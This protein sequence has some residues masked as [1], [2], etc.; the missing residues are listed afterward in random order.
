MNKKAQGAI[1]Y[2]LIIG[3]AII[4]I[5]IVVIALTGILDSGDK[6]TISTLNDYDDAQKTLRYPALGYAIKA[7]AGEIT[8]FF[9]DVTPKNSQL[10]EIFPQET[11]D[12][13]IIVNETTWYED[14]WKLGSEDINIKAGDIID[15]DLRETEEDF[16][17]KIIGEFE[18]TDG[19]CWNLEIDPIPICN[20]NDLDKIKEYPTR[21]FELK[22]NI[23]ASAT[24]GMNGGEG[25]T[26][27]GINCLDTQCGNQETCENEKG[28]GSNWIDETTQGYCSYQSEICNWWGDPCENECGGTWNTETNQ[29]ENYTPVQCNN[30][31]EICNKYCSSW[32]EPNTCPYTSDVCLWN[33]NYCLNECEGT[34]NVETYKCENYTPINCNES[35]ETCNNYCYGPWT[36]PNICLYKPTCTTQETC[37]RT[38]GCGSKW[39][40]SFTGTLDGKDYSIN[41]LTIKRNKDYTGLFARTSGATIKNIKL[42]NVNISGN[43]QTGGLIGSATN[44]TTQNIILQGNIN[45][46]SSYAGGL[47]GYNTN[48]TIT[49]SNSSG[50]INATNVYYVGGLIGYNSKGNISYSYSTSNI[51]GAAYLGGLVGQ[52]RDGHTIANSYARGEVTGTY[53]VGGLIGS[54]IGSNGNAPTLQKSYSTGKINGTGN[55]VNGFIGYRNSST[56]TPITSSYWD[57]Q[58]SGKTT[59]SNSSTGILGKTTAQMKTQSTFTSWDFTNIWQILPETNEGYPSLK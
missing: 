6:V 9:I 3:A 55:Y 50:N 39:Y 58:T 21:S 30:S 40:G 53:M 48:G 12:F 32:I 28:C 57:T 23:A 45:A 4:V 34:W 47:I 19:S 38:L 8:R 27:I 43:Q 7:I 49:K 15:L 20:L 37:E 1:E 5:A 25:F 56:Y 42:N 10:T 17:T 18:K 33:E 26:P 31:Q 14:G 2:L 16:A 29:C 46:A 36:E 35:K 24:E 11:Y 41:N 54:L 22:N 44:T 51:T 13:K 59:G 52:S